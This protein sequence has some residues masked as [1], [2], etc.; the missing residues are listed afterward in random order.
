M[1]VI[2]IF[3]QAGDGGRYIAE[4]VAQALGY[5][6]FDYGTAGRILVQ[7]GFATA[8]KVF[9]SATDFWDRFTRVGPERD[10]V[11]VMFRSLILATARNG[12]V[13]MLGRGCFAP[14]QGLSDVLNVRLKAP[15]P[16]RINRLKE[17]RRLTTEE[18][19]AH[20]A[21]TDALVADFARDSH[22]LSPDDINYFDLVI[23]TDKVPLDAAARILVDAAG[24][25]SGNRSEKPSTATLEVDPV[26]A[27]D[28][29]DEFE[30]IAH[31]RAET[32][33]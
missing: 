23:N 26:M 24:A 15:I 19:A 21:K 31:L 13:V 5:N 11:H 10:E 4:K 6:L 33:R 18:A 16:F 2:T 17:T 30:R 25:L 3:R 14:L 32:K 22:G 9:K 12:N 28:V 7:E 8:P 1:A 20:V 27:K 29:A